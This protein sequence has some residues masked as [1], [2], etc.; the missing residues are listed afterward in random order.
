LG[1]A[2]IQVVCVWAIATSRCDLLGEIMLTRQAIA[3]GC[4]RELA[5]LAAILE[6]GRS[7]LVECDKDLTL[8]LYVDLRD[9]LR[10]VNLACV[11][12]DGRPKQDEAE[13]KD[14]GV[15]STMVAQM[16][17]AVRQPAER[18]VVIV[19][20]LDL[21]AAD[22]AGLT[23]EARHVI[24]LLYEVPEMVWLGFRDPSLRLLPVVEKRFSNHLVISRPRSVTETPR[25]RETDE[26]HSSASS[27]VEKKPDSP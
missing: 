7:C 27:E 19:P 6:S 15:V 12:A 14:R 8:F 4:A 26:P 1:R 25:P 5:E 13:W 21:L 24:P 9:R 2:V 10:N 23:P 3:V 18:C 20:Y 16:L 22:S 11:Y 17:K